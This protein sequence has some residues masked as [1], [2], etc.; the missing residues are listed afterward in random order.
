MICNG[1][2]RSRTKL[3]GVT[4]SVMARNMFERNSIRDHHDGLMIRA[5]ISYGHDE[6]AQ[7]AEWLKR[8]LEGVDELRECDKAYGLCFISTFTDSDVE[9][10]SRLVG[11]AWRTLEP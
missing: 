6:H 2:P 1:Y 4:W 11:A 10:A 7:S 9:R 3:A 8:D 5:F